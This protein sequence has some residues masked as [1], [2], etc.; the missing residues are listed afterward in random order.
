M[1]LTKHAK[2]SWITLPSSTQ[3][4]ERK[5]KK[6][7]FCGSTSKGESSISKLAMMHSM[8]IPEETD[9]VKEDKEF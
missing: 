2:E 1:R 9:A 7:D 4:L 6:T 3:L 5:V 8:M